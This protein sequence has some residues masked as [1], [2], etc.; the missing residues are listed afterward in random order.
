MELF[1][2]T[3]ANGKEYAEYLDELWEKD[4]FKIKMHRHSNSQSLHDMTMY[5]IDK[6]NAL[7]ELSINPKQKT[8]CNSMLHFVINNYNKN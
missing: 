7:K 8:I 6:W 1:K 5:Y 3:G 4:Y 2:M